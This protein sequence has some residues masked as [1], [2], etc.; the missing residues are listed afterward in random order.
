M[1]IRSS[2]SVLP[3]AWLS[4]LLPEPAGTY[5]LCCVLHSLSVHAKCWLVATEPWRRGILCS[6]TAVLLQSSKSVLVGR[7]D[8]KT[9]S[10]LT[11]GQ[12]R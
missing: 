10:I 7:C 6:S 3:D 5:V 9:R 4:F 1:V 2:A 12:F 8:A 11:Q